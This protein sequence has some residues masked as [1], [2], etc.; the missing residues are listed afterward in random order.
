MI[1][2]ISNHK[3]TKVFGTKGNSPASC[4]VGAFDVPARSVIGYDKD[5]Q[6]LS[7]F[8]LAKCIGEGH[9]YAARADAGDGFTTVGEFQC[10]DRALPGFLCLSARQ[11]GSLAPLQ[12]ELH[13]GI[14]F[15]IDGFQCRCAEAG[16]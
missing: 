4:I 1:H 14:G 8:V 7:S 6:P 13:I 9:A 2:I 16:C 15:I 5:S 11:L 12:H 3:H 10:I